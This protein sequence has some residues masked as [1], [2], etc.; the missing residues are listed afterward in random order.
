MKR[1]RGPTYLWDLFGVSCFNFP[2]FPAHSYSLKVALHKYIHSTSVSRPQTQID[3]GRKPR[4]KTMITSIRVTLR[5][6][7]RQHQSC[8]QA[9]SKLSKSTSF[10]AR[11]G[12]CLAYAV[13][14]SL[15]QACTAHKPEFSNSCKEPHR[16]TTVPIMLT[17]LHGLSQRQLFVAYRTKSSL[18]SISTLYSDYCFTHSMGMTVQLCHTD[19][20]CLT[21]L[22]ICVEV[23]K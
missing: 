19:L 2:K 17:H 7:T 10:A 9:N 23:R 12:N 4:A 8:K 21:K 5:N 18:T 11:R 16:D 1:A 14:F 13:H 22:W 6:A 3:L 20:A 15:G